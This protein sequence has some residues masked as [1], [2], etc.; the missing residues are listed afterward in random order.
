[1]LKLV[2]LKTIFI[3]LIALSAGVVHAQTTIGD[4]TLSSATER[5]NARLIVED[6]IGNLHIA[7]YDNGIYYSFPD[8]AG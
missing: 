7:Y 5:N 3:I 1:M 6:N 8:D 2:I 4:S